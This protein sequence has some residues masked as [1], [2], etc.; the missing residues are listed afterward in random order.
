MSNP[1]HLEILRKGISAWNEWRVANPHVRPDLSAADLPAGDLSRADLRR[2]NLSGADLSRSDLTGVNLT[3]ANLGR[4]DLSDANLCET[5][6]FGTSLRESNLFR[7][8]L[9]QAKLCH[10]DFRGANLSQADLSGANLSGADLRG[11]NLSEANLSQAELSNACLLR[12][13]LFRANYFRANLSRSSLSEADINATYLI[14]A[15]LSKATIRGARLNRAALLNA[16]LT[17]TDCGNTCFDDT[18]LSQT[19]GLETVKHGGPSTIGLDTFFRS[20]GKIPEAFLRGCG[21]PDIFIQ[22]AASLAGKPFD[23][24]SCFISYSSKD[25]EFAQ[26]LHADLQ[27]KGVR[28]WFAP[29]DLKIGDIFRVTIDETIRVYDKLLLVLSEDSVRSDWVEKE[30]EAAFE[31]E[32]QQKRTMLF[33]IRLDDAVMNIPTGWPADIRRTRHIGD[34]HAWRTHDTYQLAFA[35]LLR[36]LKATQTPPPTEDKPH[37]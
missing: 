21:V 24:Y 34:F 6:C 3:G 25:Q 20:E 9:C 26:R 12:A 37:D 14:E 4:A 2:A 16:N 7:A 29:E 35:R 36:D 28:C 8:K 17:E 23:Y 18:D 11:G 30:V 5:N 32:G 15:D 31:K 22:Y 10:A 13:N 33:P 1:E 19:I 27:A